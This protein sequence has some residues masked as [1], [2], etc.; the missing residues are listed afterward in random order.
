MKVE[1]TII[2][3]VEVMFDELVKRLGPEIPPSS[4]VE[5]VLSTNDRIIVKLKDNVVAKVL[6]KQVDM[7][8]PVQPIAG[9]GNAPSPTI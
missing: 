4:E 9:G 2:T 8:A 7:P 5:T 6:A 3:R 1:R